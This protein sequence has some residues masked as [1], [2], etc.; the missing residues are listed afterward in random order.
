M[1]TM[2][3]RWLAWGLVAVVAASFGCASMRPHAGV[4]P[5]ASADPD[6]LPAPAMYATLCSQCHGPEA[7]GYAADHAPSLV[8]P[9]FLASATDDFLHRSIGQGRPGTAMAAYD[10]SVGGPLDT[11]AIDKLVAWLR[12][13]GPAS[14]ELPRAALGDSARGQPLYATHC[15]RCHGDLAKRGDAVMIVNPGFLV[16]ASDA[17]IRHAILEGR[18]GTPMASFR[19]TLDSTQVADVGAWVRSQ[20]TS[21]DAAR[22]P[23]PTGREP[24]FGYPN[25]K[26]PEFTLR[27]HRYV[28]VEEVNR[29]LQQHRKLVIVDA[30]PASE[31]RSTHIVT[32][33]SI[34][35]YKV[36]RIDE[37]PTDATIVAYCAC[38]HHLSGAVVDS[39]RAHG[40]EHA[41][42][43][44]EGVLEWERRGYPIVAAPG[45]SL[46]PGEMHNAPAGH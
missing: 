32:A 15:Q 40:R 23:A 2:N 46:P 22:L 43:L 10:R 11:E 19:G 3:M 18:P 41:Y 17:F 9:T 12:T 16:V 36:D 28:G 1:Q 39:L 33:I 20:A 25:G 8:N 30:R 5:A 21:L 26:A 42:V 37:I 35:H 24:L 31:W 34:P 45:V 44:D 14:H 27:D 7:R 4:R 29:A 6:S 13:H 38:P